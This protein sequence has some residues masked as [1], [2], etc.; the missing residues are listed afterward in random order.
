MW[1]ARLA[2]PVL[3]SGLRSVRA[4]QSLTCF[5]YKDSQPSHWA[6]LMFSVH[7]SVAARSAGAVAP[8]ESTLPLAQLMKSE[9]DKRPLFAIIHLGFCAPHAV[10]LLIRRQAGNSTR[11]RT[12]TWLW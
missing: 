7:C 10:A 12:T 5:L 11:S 9:A 4:N 6:A 1:L 8:G 2:R 3:R